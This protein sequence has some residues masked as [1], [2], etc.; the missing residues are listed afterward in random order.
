MV[1]ERTSKI[2]GVKQLLNR[3][4]TAC[5]FDPLAVEEET[6]DAELWTL[7]VFYRAQPESCCVQIQAIEAAALRIEFS[8]PPLPLARR[9]AQ[10]KDY[11]VLL[12]RRNGLKNKGFWRYGYQIPAECQQFVVLEDLATLDVT[13]FHEAVLEVILENQWWRSVLENRA[14]TWADEPWE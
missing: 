8:S 9:F 12:M 4:A 7:T 11:A 5:G 10:T 13:K 2:E 6:F 1:D 14:R 3:L